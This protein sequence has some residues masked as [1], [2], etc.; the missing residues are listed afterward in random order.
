MSIPDLPR[1][2]IIVSTNTLKLFLPESSAPTILYRRARRIR[3]L[4]GKSTYRSGSEITGPNTSLRSRLY[5]SLIVPWKINALDPS[6]LFTSLYMGLLYAVFY[7]FFEF[8]PFVYGNVYGMNTG[9]IGLMSL[10]VVISII[11]AGV[12]YVLY[13]H[14]VINKSLRAG[15]TM[16]PE[17]RLAPALVAS[18]LISAGLFIF[19]WTSRPSV[20]IMVPT[21]GVGLVTGGTILILQ[22]IFV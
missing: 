2:S 21:V 15:K 1:Q 11:I 8:F 13:I 9:Q 4:T 16:T 10:T 6:I 19:A 17:D 3:A 20:H 22:C 14:F 7:S 5:A 18:L 12:P